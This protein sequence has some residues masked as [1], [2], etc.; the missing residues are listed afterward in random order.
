MPMPCRTSAA[1]VCNL[2]PDRICITGIALQ[3]PCSFIFDP[4]HTF[5]SGIGMTLPTINVAMVKV[6]VVTAI[7]LEPVNFSTDAVQTTVQTLYIPFTPVASYPRRLSSLAK[8]LCARCSLR[9]SLAVKEPSLIPAS[10]L[11][12]CLFILRS[13][14]LS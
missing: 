6:P 4:G 13:I 5:P 7:V 9:T 8:R 14:L 11:Y 3:R 10:I 2:P 1:L 12:C